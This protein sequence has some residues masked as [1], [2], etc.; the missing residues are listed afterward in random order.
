MLQQTTWACTMLGQSLYAHPM[1]WTAFCSVKSQ[2]AELLNQ[3]SLAKLL[4][5][6]TETCCLAEIPT[7]RQFCCPSQPC[8]IRLAAQPAA[9]LSIRS[10]EYEACCSSELSST[11]PAVFTACT[12][13]LLVQQPLHQV[14]QFISNSPFLQVFQHLNS[15][16]CCVAVLAIVCV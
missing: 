16:L 3:S 10:A 8:T 6:P 1:Q 15:F 11:R 13:S 7:R 2:T 5:L 12:T 14:G 9:L 4:G